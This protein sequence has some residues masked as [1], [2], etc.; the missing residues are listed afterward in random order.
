MANELTHLRE[1][2]F[3]YGLC[4]R[5]HVIRPSIFLQCVERIIG[6]NLSD[7]KVS[8]HDGTFSDKEIDTLK[9]G[10]VLAQY[11][12]DK[13]ILKPPFD[14]VQWVGNTHGVSPCDVV[15]NGVGFS[16]KERSFILENMGLYKYLNLMT[17]SD[18]KRGKLH[19]FE[20]FAK[21]D[22]DAWFL[23]TRDIIVNHLRQKPW[24]FIKDKNTYEMTLH[25]NNLYASINNER[26]LIS[27]FVGM[28]YNQ[29]K[30]KDTVP[31]VYKEKCVSRFI[32]KEVSNNVEYIKC[33]K[34]CAE[35]AGQ[36]IISYIKE[37][38]FPDKAILTK[39]FRF[40]E[41]Q[42]YYYAKV[43]EQSPTV[44][45]VPLAGENIKCVE[46][47]DIKYSI[48]ISQ[49]NIITKLRIKDTNMEINLRNEIRYS[50]GQLNGT[51]EAK[52]YY[53]KSSDL[54]YEKIE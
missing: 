1:L 31:A 49:L 26:Y 16:L 7:I 53:D 36:N 10:I 51:P 50:H 28:D 5:S 2:S 3:I 11:V 6:C 52:L 14:T 33:K 45:Y 48:L 38:F 8:K 46:M 20:Y 43:V 25:G 30:D 40:S 54:P 27:D 29:Y 15:V 18:F 34:A 19:A 44:Y 32:N 4:H 41:T 35:K 21:D 12:K 23:C 24:H 37:N 17:G 39:L 47:V 13:H 42:A 9:N 22:L